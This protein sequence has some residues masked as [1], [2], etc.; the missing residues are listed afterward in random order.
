MRVPADP[1]GLGR[2][3]NRDP[4]DVIPVDS[5]VANA[6]QVNRLIGPN[7]NLMS[8]RVLRIRDRNGF[9]QMAPLN[10]AVAPNANGL[11]LTID[12]NGD[13]PGLTGLMYRRG[14]LR[15]GLEPSTNNED[16]VG[17][18]V[19]LVDAYRY[20]LCQDPTDATNLKLVRERIDAG[21]LLNPAIP[22]AVSS[23][24]CGQLDPVFQDGV[25]DNESSLY[26][27]AI[28]DNVVDFQVWVDCTDVNG[29]ALVNPSW[30]TDWRTPNVGDAGSDCL[31]QDNGQAASLARI[32]HVR[33]SVRSENERKDLENFGFYDNTGLDTTTS[34]TLAAGSLQTF[35][36]NGEPTNAARLKTFQTDINLRNFSILNPASRQP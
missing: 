23:P 21:L 16:D 15:E 28:A 10:D 33:F 2:L 14:G 17:Y 13:V 27:V 1:R 6:A 26:Q 9:V 29:A 11:T 12:S 18:E 19:S 8:K 24:L 25:N 31:S 22:D 36:I 30:N 20:R 4:F 32:L 3:F 5:T 35:D 7:A 34:P